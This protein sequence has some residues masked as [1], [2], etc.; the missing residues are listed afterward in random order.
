MTLLDFFIGIND[1]KQLHFLVFFFLSFGIGM[2]M[3][4]LTPNG[5]T[6]KGLRYMW[7]FLVFIG[8]AEEFR[9]Y[10]L[11]DRTAEFFDAVANL[12]GVTCGLFIPFL[13][14]Y[15]RNAIIMK[16]LSIPSNPLVEWLV[17]L[18]FYVILWV[19]NQEPPM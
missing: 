6:I 2:V 8:M 4:L 1:D 7:L 11:P 17:V 14:A 5:Y 18:P 15:L 3:L 19:F 16:R 13:L 10:F 9:Q 12:C